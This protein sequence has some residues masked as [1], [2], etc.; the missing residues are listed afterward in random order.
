MA[1]LNFGVVLRDPLGHPSVQLF[2][3]RQHVLPVFDVLQG[4]G[5]VPER[6]KL[7]GRRKYSIFS[8]PGVM[9]C[10][11]HSR[12]RSMR[13]AMSRLIPRALFMVQ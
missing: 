6:L 4:C 7:F 10:R 2:V 5:G 13:S 3:A 12:V 11:M 1:N 9:R 8:E